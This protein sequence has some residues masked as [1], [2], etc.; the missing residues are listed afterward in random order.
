MCA[1]DLKPTFQTGQ[2]FPLD[3]GFGASAQVMVTVALPCQVLQ[4][5]LVDT[6]GP[7]PMGSPIQSLKG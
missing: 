2:E 7:T 3:P 6:A 5:S 4:A 1:V